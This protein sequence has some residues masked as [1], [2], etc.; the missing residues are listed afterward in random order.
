MSDLQ[1]IVGYRIYHK[2]GRNWKCVED[3]KSITKALAF[4]KDGLRSNQE[5]RVKKLR[6]IDTLYVVRHYCSFDGWIDVSKPMPKKDAEKFK[7][8]RDAKLHRG[9]QYAQSYH[10]IFPA[11]TQMLRTPESL[12]R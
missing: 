4:V 7:V 9:P 10:D 3:V 2:D 8:E 11:N 1:K 6:L 5:L 12:G